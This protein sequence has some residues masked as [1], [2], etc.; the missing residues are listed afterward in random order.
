MTYR[1]HTLGQLALAQLP[2]HEDE[3]LSGLPEVH[4][5]T[6]D[7]HAVILIFDHRGE[8]WTIEVDP[9]EAAPPD[10]DDGTFLY[11]HGQRV[12]LPQHGGVGE[13]VLQRLTR[14]AVLGDVVEYAVECPD[15]EV[16]WHYE[17]DLIAVEER[18]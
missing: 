13:V 8:L 6:E 17:P 1:E 10:T 14:R 2:H 5:T 3:N 7:G 16:V 15:G 9:A 4:V 18:P 11:R 12:Q